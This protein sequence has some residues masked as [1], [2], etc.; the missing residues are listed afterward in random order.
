MASYDF[1]CSTCGTF[2]VRVPMQALT[3]TVGCPTC[4]QPARRR[5]TP[6]H[7]RLMAPALTRAMDAS[8]ASRDRPQVVDALPP[9]SGPRNVTT[10]PLHR[11]LPRP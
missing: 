7:T 3:P 1:T 4:A 8:E 6:P 5:Y 11:R 2:T 10:H 9:R